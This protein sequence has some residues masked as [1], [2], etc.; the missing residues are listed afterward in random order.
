MARTPH[1]TQKRLLTEQALRDIESAEAAYIRSIEKLSKL[2]EPKLEQATS[3]LTL[4]YRE[5]LMLIDSAIAELRAG[6]AHPQCRYETGLIPDAAGADD[7]HVHR[8][9]RLL[10][11]PLRRYRLRPDGE[12][13]LGEIAHVAHA[14]LDHQALHAMCPKR[15]RQ[16]L[17]EIAVIARTGR[18]HD[19]DVAVAALLD[20]DR[21]GDQ[22]ALVRVVVEPLEQLCEPL[23]NDRTATPGEA[24]HGL[25]VGD[26][27]DAGYH[28]DRQARLLQAVEK[29]EIGVGL[30]EELGD[31]ARGESEQ[32]RW[33]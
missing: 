33:F 27:Q 3:P 4:T 31:G 7:R 11:G 9:D 29:A 18:R 22:L 13:H 32:T 20:R 17:A 25:E 21:G 1:E 5:R 12:L 6:I 8:A 15:A 16:E 28:R 23:R 2:V 30:E 10:D 14:C 19:E 26:R 24:C